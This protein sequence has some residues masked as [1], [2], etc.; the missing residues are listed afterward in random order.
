MT[1]L[2]LT[3]ARIGEQSPHATES[4]FTA[5]Q[6]AKWERVAAHVKQPSTARTEKPRAE[7]IVSVVS[8]Y[9]CYYC[10]HTPESA[11]ALM[12]R[13]TCP[14]LWQTRKIPPLS[15][16]GT[17]EMRSTTERVNH[18]ESVADTID[19]GIIRVGD[20]AY[21]CKRCGRSPKADQK[22][23]MRCRACGHRADTIDEQGEAD[24]AS[25]TPIGSQPIGSRHATDAVI[26]EAA[27]GKDNEPATGARTG[28]RVDSLASASPT[29]PP[30]PNH[31]P[32]SDAKHLN[33]SLLCYWH[34]AER[35]L[36]ARD[37]R[38][39]ADNAEINRMQT[40]LAEEVTIKRTLNESLLKRYARIAALEKAHEERSNE[41][42][43]WFTEATAR[44]KEIAA[45]EAENARLRDS[46]RT[47]DPRT[48][49]FKEIGEAF[50]AILERDEWTQRRFRSIENQLDTLC[51]YAPEPRLPRS[52]AGATNTSAVP[53]W[54]A[55]GG[56]GS[57]PDAATVGRAADVPTPP[58]SVV[59]AHALTWRQVH[60]AWEECWDGANRDTFEKIAVFLSKRVNTSEGAAIRED[61][62]A[63][64]RATSPSDASPAAWTEEQREDA[65]SKIIPTKGDDAAL[66]GF[67][68]MH[69][70]VPNHCASRELYWARELL[71]IRRKS[72]ETAES[73]A[74]ATPASKSAAKELDELLSVFAGGDEDCWTLP[75]TR[76]IQYM[77]D[78]RW[79]LSVTLNRAAFLAEVNETLRGMLCTLAGYTG[80]HFGMDESCKNYERVLKQ[81][82]DKKEPPTCSAPDSGWNDDQRLAA[83]SVAAVV[84][85]C[86]TELDPYDDD[87]AEL[88]RQMEKYG[89]RFCTEIAK[90]AHRF[91]GHAGASRRGPPSD[92][93]QPASNSSNFERKVVGDV[94]VEGAGI[95]AS[96]TSAPSISPQPA[97]R[98]SEEHRD[99]ASKVLGATFSSD[100]NALCAEIA[101]HAHLF[102]QYPAARE[103]SAED[104]TRAV[105]A[106]CDVYWLPTG[107]TIDVIVRAALSSIGITV[108]E[109][110]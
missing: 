99:A 95:T 31:F 87:S 93:S 17:A 66:E 7:E 12:E 76:A 21:N 88:D 13:D 61:A 48:G 33:D 77:S 24:E 57:E 68:A 75:A 84:W 86:T 71:A 73:M 98:W 102:C 91:C 6:R 49:P 94:P 78:I 25:R 106:G 92:A 39:A 64:N 108:K 97:A 40:R 18:A 85:H 29:L 83:R 109:P 89:S 54:E 19:D 45:L 67:V 50:E 34:A 96:A 43:K 105:S 90:H 5:G 20:V 80:T 14:H 55:G 72:R 37:A 30:W 9:I 42:A 60:D 101:K 62:G 27:R 69:I 23:P 51:G 53:V 74:S 26:G 52:S 103:I 70:G 79:D 59:D 10:K 110:Q 41:L 1:P 65:S 32:A 56:T 11:A 107:G 22:D 28:D 63:V 4:S 58:A 81:L 35:A 100:P 15:A 16:S 104:F 38:I 47:D 44:G 3:L 8:D 82:T 2:W 36:Y 46:A